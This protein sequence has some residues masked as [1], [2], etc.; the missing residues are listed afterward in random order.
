MIKEIFKECEFTF[1]QWNKLFLYDAFLK[2]IFR[3]D[4]IDMSNERKKDI[5][6][7]NAFNE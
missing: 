3:H 7:K 2:A 6:L 5:L 4:Y 1:R